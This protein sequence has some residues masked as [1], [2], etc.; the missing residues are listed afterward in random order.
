LEFAVIKNEYFL[1]I[2]CQKHLY[3]KIIRNNKEFTTK[4]NYV[5]YIEL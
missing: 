3:L 1:F 2:L 4:L 5:N